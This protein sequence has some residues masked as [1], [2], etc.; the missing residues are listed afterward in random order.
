ML[1]T[2]LRVLMQ[3][4]TQYIKHMDRVELCE[5]FRGR[6]ILN[7]SGLTAADKASL[8]R[9]CPTRAIAFGQKLTLD[10]G[11][12]L[13]C[14]ECAVRFPEH[15]RF[16]ND[17][18][19]ASSTREGLVVRENQAD[20]WGFDQTAVRPEIRSLFG[21]SLHL[22]EVSA[23]GDNSCEMELGAAGNVNFDMGRYG[24]EFTASP[25]HADGVVVTGPVT[26][27][28]A[29]ELETTW[30]AVPEPKIL[31]AVGADAISGG[32]FAESPAVNR[33]FFDI[34]KPDLY[35]P[36]NPAHPM[37]FITGVLALIRGGS[38]GTAADPQNE[39]EE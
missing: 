5:E 21:R 25:R 11:K 35:V 6:P 3:H 8:C 18:R 16:T 31:I 17:Y 23:G 28:M 12:C 27:N 14:G 24:I 34:H 26:A 2:S 32:L 19:L 7:G 15:V 10:M 22:R 30:Q 29:R 4:R 1:L 9:M 37:T 20:A 39:R 38:T 33:K 13:F 36:G